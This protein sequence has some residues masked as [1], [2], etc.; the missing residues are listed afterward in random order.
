MIKGRLTFQN[1]GSHSKSRVLR[2]RGSGLLVSV[3]IISWAQAV[4][5]TEYHVPTPGSSPNSVTAGPDGALCGQSLRELLK[6]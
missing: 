3:S 1:N 5:V 6:G 2:E 4:T